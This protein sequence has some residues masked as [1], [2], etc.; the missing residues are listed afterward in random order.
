[1]GRDVQETSEALRNVKTKESTIFQ[2]DFND[3]VENNAEVLKSGS[4]STW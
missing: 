1:M 3:H 4:V 2:G